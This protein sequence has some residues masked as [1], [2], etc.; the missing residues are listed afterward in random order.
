MPNLM[1][2]ALICLALLLPP[3]ALPGRYT[4]DRPA[5][6]DPVALVEE[7]VRDANRLQRRRVRSEL[8]ALLTPPLALDIKAVEPGFAITADGNRT[9]RA[10][11]GETDVAM[12]TSNG[13]SA[14]RSTELRGEALVIRIAGENGSR[15]QV[16]EAREGRLVVTTTYTVSFR[17]API[18]Q[19]T[20]YLRESP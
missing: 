4:L 7:A 17:R 6:D 20:V 15:E 16:L 8:T 19:R 5:S 1:S 11:P 13:D 2:G 3:D 18:K 14:R 10:T 12:Q 9:M